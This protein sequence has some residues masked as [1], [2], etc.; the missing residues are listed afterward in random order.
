MTSLNNFVM[1]ESIYGKFIVNRYCYYQAEALIKTGATH[2]ESELNNIKKIINAL[3]EGAVAIDAGANIGFVSIPM[4]NILTKKN[5]MVFAFE[6]QRMLYYALCGTATLNDLSNLKIINSALGSKSG[7][8]KIPPQNY[9]EASDFGRLSLVKQKN[10]ESSD[11]VDVVR[12][13][14][15]NLHRL[16]FLKIDV[17]GMEIDV[18]AGAMESI[19]K[20]RPYCWIEYWMIDKDMLIDQ[21][22]GLNYNIY[23]MDKLNVLCA[24]EEKLKEHNFNISAPNL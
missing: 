6:P 24:P 14:D 17:E 9:G 5:G 20:Y 15:M 4:A 1:I 19:K 13:D 8:L 18:L 16:D 2:I 21:F 3:P 23:K 22:K 11:V 10:I 7:E 12:I